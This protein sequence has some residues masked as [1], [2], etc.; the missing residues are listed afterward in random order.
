MNTKKKI[1]IIGL[2]IAAVITALIFFGKDDRPI[3]NISLKNNKILNRSTIIGADMIVAAG[4]NELKI[5]SIHV[6]ITHMPN[7]T[8][9]DLQYQA[10]IMP[11]VPRV[12][13][14]RIKSLSRNTAIEVLAH[15]LIHLKQMHTNILFNTKDTIYWGIMMYDV[16]NLPDYFDRPWEIQ[17]FEEQI[18]LSKGIKNLIYK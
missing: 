16:N 2:L 13:N 4:L 7:K 14:I 10:Y 12:Y 15:E 8:K 3:S 1:L 5:D 6:L 17:A 11:I 9:G 18:E